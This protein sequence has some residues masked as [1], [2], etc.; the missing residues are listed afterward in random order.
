VAV[1]PG[2][3]VFWGGNVSAPG[4]EGGGWFVRRLASNGAFV[5]HRDQ[6]G[7]ED[8]TSSTVLHDL[9]VGDS[10]VALALTD[11]GCCADPFQDGWIRAIRTSGAFAWN[12]DFEPP[13]GTP[14]GYYDRAT[15]VAV[16]ALDTV[17]AS[18][19]AA[20]ES[21]PDDAARYEG[22][23]SLQK[24]TSGGAVV[25]R[26]K[27]LRIPY[28]WTDAMVAVRGDRLMVTT[29]SRGQFIYWGT[30]TPPEG[31]LGRFSLDG[32]L[33][34]WRTWGTDWQFAALP[35]QLAI[36]ADMN[37]WVVGWRRD[38]SDHGYDAF[39]RK[40]SPGGAVLEAI[41]MDG[42]TRHLHGTGVA[43]RGSG[44]MMT[45]W[46]GTQKWDNLGGGRLWRL[47]V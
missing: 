45:G 31:W 33:V 44:A 25:W 18:G 22:M 8:C 36:D 7:W 1:G 41:A 38:P 35:Q 34:W 29:Q 4:C 46:V 9:D 21:I 17:Y 37:T 27:V 5:W 15:G 24:M 19:W 40:Y 14:A 43:A 23:A 3:G 39:A 28:V 10:L 42:P 26:K 12:R 13:A 20:T 32:D 16:S 6:A 2:G 11:R 47:V 30:S